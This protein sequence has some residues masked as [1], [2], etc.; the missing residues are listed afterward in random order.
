MP[1]HGDQPRHRVRPTTIVASVLA[2]VLALGGFLLWRESRSGPPTGTPSCSWPLTIRGTA[3][4]AQSGLVRCYVRA[5]SRR[6][7]GALQGLALPDPPV[8]VTAAQLVHA[9]DARVGVAT[10][11]FTPNPNDSAEATVEITYG[12]GA[13]DVLSMRY[14]NPAAESW[15]LVIGAQLV[16]PSGGPPPA[17][18]T[19]GA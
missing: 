6:D 10:A 4:A 15:R 16:S 13:R 14:A 12:D 19:P 17:S 1:L 8:R 18:G 7:L 3:D 11:T 9:A 2:V 5:V